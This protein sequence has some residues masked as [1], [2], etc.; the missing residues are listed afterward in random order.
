VNVG[1]LRNYALLDDLLSKPE[2][3]IELQS[4]SLN[5]HG[6]GVLSG[7]FGVRDETERRAAARKAQGKVQAC[8]T[9]ADD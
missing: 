7:A 5:D 4:S 6:A 9:S 2:L 8:R 1:R 3:A